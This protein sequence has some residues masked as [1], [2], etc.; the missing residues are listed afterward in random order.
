MSCHTPNIESAKKSSC[1]GYLK[2][3]II[4]QTNKGHRKYISGTDSV[5]V[6][7]MSF[8]DMC[9]FFSGSCLLL[10]H[11]TFS[12]STLKAVC[13]SQSTTPLCL[14]QQAQKWRL[15]TLNQQRRGPKRRTWGLENSWGRRRLG[16]THRRAKAIVGSHPRSPLSVVMHR[17]VFSGFS[18][19]SCSRCHWWCLQHWR[20]SVWFCC[21]SCYVSSQFSSFSR[22]YARGRHFAGMEH[23]NIYS[24]V[25]FSRN[26]AND[27][28]CS[29]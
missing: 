9:C 23:R 20:R 2:A 17:N 14:F 22:H 4:L 28:Q 21:F 12:S 6:S 26:L 10:R 16:V 29:N 5:Q 15:V 25:Y 19:I 11:S 24:I 8:S 7:L 13:Y 18:R 3:L 27:R 1:K